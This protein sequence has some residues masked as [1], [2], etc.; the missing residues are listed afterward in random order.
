MTQQEQSRHIF[1]RQALDA[2]RAPE[3]GGIVLIR[4]FPLTLVTTGAVSMAFLVILLFAFGT[5]TRR[6]T[7]DGVLMPDTGLV[8]I[9]AQQ[10]GIVLSKR[11]V[12]GQHV[13]RGQALYT[14]STDLQSAVA[15]DTQAALIQQSKQRKASLQQELAKTRQ[16]HREER[17][18]LQSKVA[19][20]RT[21]LAGIDDQIAAQRMRTSLAADA[22]ARYAS[23][24]ANDYT[25]KDQAQQRDADLLDQRS[26]LNSLERDRA[27]TT[28][29]LKVAV[30]ELSGLSL[31]QENQLSQLDRNVID[32]DQ[33]LIESEAKRE[34][35][36][37]APETGTATA[38]IA[39]P[40]QMVDTSH[41]IASVVPTGARWQAYLFVPS[42][43]VGFIRVGD[44][45]LIRYQAFPYQKFGQYEAN[46]V[47]IARAALSSVE[48]ATN[49]GLAGKD[50][51]YYRVTVALKVQHVSAYGKPQPLQA[52]MTLQADV[53]QEHRRLYE[54]V[55]EP[56][57]SLT[58]KL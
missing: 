5:Y 44:H 58:G 12:E 43:A 46:V 31:K 22:S 55:L 4:P 37:T 9:Y 33:S 10:G 16:I 19:S 7:V 15:G 49:G 2:H 20:L 51:T 57:Y 38:V 18:T 42:T 27:S 14:I 11:I 36:I 28:Q 25:T 56:L 29:L 17:D 39:E 34:L 35:V 13:V 32:V 45:V 6:T 47:S 30:N 23:L 54:W 50:G 1:R 52:G 41:P 53:L 3:F 40:G 48:L 21:Q 24:L 26:K 8:K